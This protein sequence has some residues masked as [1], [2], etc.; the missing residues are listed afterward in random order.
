MHTIYVTINVLY[1]TYTYTQC[2]YIK[3]V[4]CIYYYN[5]V[6]KYNLICHS[7]KPGILEHKFRVKYHTNYLILSSVQIF[8]ILFNY[9]VLRFSY[10][11]IITFSIYNYK[12]KNFFYIINQKTNIIKKNT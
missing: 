11:I 5:N 4:L 7:Q 1:D 2:S 12:S 6:I 8:H 10:I 9:L 3:S